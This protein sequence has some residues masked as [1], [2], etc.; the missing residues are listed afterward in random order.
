MKISS[1]AVLAASAVAAAVIVP[2]A[3]FAQK[4]GG[5][6]KIY[7]RGTPPSASIHE[8]ATTST[9]MPSSCRKSWPT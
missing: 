6:M 2:T 1:M 9:I 4:P 5:I 7:H 8:E 3:A